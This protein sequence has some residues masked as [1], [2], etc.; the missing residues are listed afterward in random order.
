MAIN[1][2]PWKSQHLFHV[3]F[4]L[5]LL[6]LF[7]REVKTEAFLFLFVNLCVIKVTFKDIKMSDAG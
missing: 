2:Q 7:E 1:E 4:F 6:Y 3:F 5:L